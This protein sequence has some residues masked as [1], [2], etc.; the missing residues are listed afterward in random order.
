[1]VAAAYGVISACSTHGS[2]API[3]SAQPAGHGS[4]L[5]VPADHSIKSSFPSEPL[6][7]L[8]PLQTPFGALRLR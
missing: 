7:P 1:M 3:H 8:Y 2:S 6:Y 4:Q 5:A